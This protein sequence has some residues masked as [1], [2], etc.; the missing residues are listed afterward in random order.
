MKTPFLLLPIL[1]LLIVS[2]E[3]SPLP[4]SYRVQFP[5]APALWTEVLGEN[6]WR[7]GYYD[8]QG[9]FR[10]AEITGNSPA[11][12]TISILKEWPNAILAWP[13]WSENGLEAG[14][15]C[16][17]GAI[18][19][20]D[21]TGNTIALSWEAGV[22]AF[23]FREMDKAQEFNTGTNR[24]PKYFD[25]K[26]FRSFFWEDAPEELKKD[27]WLANWK[28]IAEKSIRS[29]FRKSYVRLEVRTTRE[30]TIPHVGPWFGASPFRQVEIWEKGEEVI[31]PLSSH[32]EI[33]VCPGGRF[34]V[35][36]KMQLWVPFP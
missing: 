8:S 34:Y 27:P 9:L 32:P 20:F 25:W 24:E 13:Y 35:S 11:G 2:C 23:F 7:L 18:Y 36:S 4:E 33:L 1:I 16:P 10:Q 3:G 30:I 31:L 26:R 29:G 28:E 17:A 15:F 12:V 5:A 22:E 14:F 19:P 21:I 6:Q